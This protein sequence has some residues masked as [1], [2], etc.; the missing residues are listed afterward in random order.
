MLPL[1]SSVLCFVLA[2]MLGAQWW[3]RR[4]SYQLVW[5]IGLLFY[6]L[7]AG[8]D[9]SGQLAGWN[10]SLYRLWYFTGAIAVAAWLGLGSIYLMQA[11]GFG[12]VAALGVFVGAVPALIRGG[13]LLG[14]HEDAL[15]Q[16]L[17]GLGIAGIAAAGTIAY[18]SWEKPEWTGHTTLLLLVA[19]SMVAA[20]RIA[21]TPVD[22]SQMVDSTT[23]IPHGAAFPETVRLISPLFNIAGA[24]ALFWGA[25]YSGWTFW[26]RRLYPQ[27]LVSNGLIAL[28]ALAPSL[29][30]SLNRFGITGVFY[31]GE[32][33]G[34][35]LIFA[36]VVASSGAS[37]RRPPVEGEPE[38]SGIP[39]RQIA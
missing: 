14:A 30:S 15:A 39:S 33:L 6:G 9:A 29:T 4:R 10:E 34:V 35:L 5:C 13:K 17:I 27:R 26:R 32:L 1:I 24:L 18:V 25:V 2:G 7:A 31:W 22:V 36:G 11:T 8:A 23:G 12:E 21:L 19:G 37:A 38:P 16:S 3:R 20:M 28:G